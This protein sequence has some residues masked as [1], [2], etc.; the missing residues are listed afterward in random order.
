M[1]AI[2]E[3]LEAKIANITRGSVSGSAQGQVQGRVNK[4]DKGRKASGLQGSPS[5]SLSFS[6]SSMA[7]ESPNSRLEELYEEGLKKTA[8]LERKRELLLEKECSFHP[9]L[10]RKGKRAPGPRGSARAAQLYEKAVQQRTRQEKLRKVDPSECT[11]SPDITKKAK[12]NGKRTSAKGMSRFDMP[13]SYTHLTLPT[14]PY[15]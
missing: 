8:K 11:F 9:T 6:S 15:V 7:N 3:G 2:L 14:T 10:T 13:V 12:A 1:S 5:S 4:V